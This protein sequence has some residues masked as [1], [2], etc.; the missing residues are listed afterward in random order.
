MSSLVELEN[1]TTTQLSYEGN[2]TL[3]NLSSNKK[4]TRKFVKFDIDNIIIP[5]SSNS[6]NCVNSNVNC[7]DDTKPITYI[8]V[9]KRDSPV[10]QFTL[11]PQK[12]SNQVQK[13]Q[14]LEITSMKK[15]DAM[16]E[17]QYKF[18]DNFIAVIDRKTREEINTKLKSVSNYKKTL[19]VLCNNDTIT[20]LKQDSKFNFSRKQF[21]SRN[22]QPNKTFQYNLREK[23]KPLIPNAWIT[24]KE[25]KDINTYCMTFSQLK[26][27]E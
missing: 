4:K 6:T 3:T 17:A 23:I 21:F 16:I 20:I 12:Q 1:N 5:Q 27:R 26:Y 22:G 25:S 2:S 8:S 19:F 14:T 15:H 11:Q 24:F 18:I 7:I 9:L 10:Q 13:I